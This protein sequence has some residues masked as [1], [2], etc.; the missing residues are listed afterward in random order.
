MVI[1]ATKVNGIYT[2]DPMK[3]PTAT[4][5]DVVSHQEVI[6]KNLRIMDLTAVAM[7]KDNNLSMFV[8]KMEDIHLLSE[9]DLSFGTIV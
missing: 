8:C 6:E 5:Y 2:A 7:A 9:Q 4:R 1:K 3:D